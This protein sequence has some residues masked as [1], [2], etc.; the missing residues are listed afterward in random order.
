MPGIRT[1]RIY[2]PPS[3]EDGERLLI[4]RFWPRGI[5]KDAVDG[6]ERDLA[7]SAE[8]LRAYRSGPMEWEELARR[9][10][11]EMGEK[12]ELLAELSARGERGTVTLLCSCRDESR[13]HRSL[14]KALVE[15][16]DP[17]PAA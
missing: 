15:E 14:L 6:W 1:K 3:P 10:R 11:A 9:Y 2:D 8:L 12:R 16:S 4:M 13:C 5:R 7:P 17:G